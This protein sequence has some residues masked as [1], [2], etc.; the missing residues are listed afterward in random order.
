MTPTNGGQAVSGQTDSSG[1]YRFDSL[2]TGEYE[3]TVNY[4]NYAPYTETVTITD[5]EL[6]RQITLQKGGQCG[7]SVYW[8]LDGDTLTIYG[9]G[10]M[11]DN[12]SWLPFN[13]S[14][15][16][17]KTTKLQVEEGVTTIGDNAFGRL[18]TWQV[19]EISLPSTL[20]KIGYYAFKS[21]KNLYSI[22][23]PDSV[24]TIDTYAFYYCYNLK[25]I[26]LPANLV[27]IGWGAFY[28]CQITSLELPDSVQTIG[29]EAFMNCSQLK[30]VELNEGLQSIGYSAFEGCENLT[31]IH[32]P[33][34]VTSIGTSAFATCDEL[35]EATLPSQL[36]VIPDELFWGDELLTSIILPQSLTEIGETAFAGT[37]LTSVEI[38][39][40]VKKIGDSAFSGCPLTSVTLPSQLE[41]IG[42]GAF[43][44]CDSLTGDLTLPNSVHSI[45][46]SA[47]H[48]T[49]LSSIHM[50][51]VSQ[52]GEGAFMDPNYYGKM[53]DT[54]LH[55][56]YGGTK[57]QFDS[58]IKYD[59]NTKTYEQLGFA[60]KTI[61]CADSNI[62]VPAY[63][64]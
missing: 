28:D 35:A 44:F 8:V 56:Y 61:H 22:D 59:G 1:A 2:R 36:T 63:N 17:E 48:D 52:I 32:I 13:L 53:E 20:V 40:G 37:A 21:C 49:K 27:T 54:L 10:P 62:V 43:Q 46:E 25:T 19:S 45:G 11:Y 50:G 60:G 57:A 30:T 4:T 26:H 29:D 58:A 55:I 14:S 24:T 34:S 47:F 31:A 33:E 7:E 5:S 41:E 39:D 64:L 16:I 3:L 23:I 9:E 6:T 15:A 38:P 42:S 51:A 18:T 12:S